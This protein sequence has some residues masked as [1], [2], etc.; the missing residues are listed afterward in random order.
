MHIVEFESGEFAVR[1]W[2]FFYLSITLA[3]WWISDENVRSFCLNRTEDEARKLAL[4]YINP[5]KIQKL[6]IKRR[7]AI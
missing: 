5:P 2:P 3:Y 1:R 7:I 4:K 6:K